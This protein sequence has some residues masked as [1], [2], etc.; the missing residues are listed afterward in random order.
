MRLG[1]DGLNMIRSRVNRGIEANVAPAA[2]FASPHR[3]GNCFESE[4][5][6]L[7]DLAGIS[8]AEAN[9]SA[10]L[11]ARSKET[12]PDAGRQIFTAYLHVIEDDQP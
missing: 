2:F 10:V 1:A 4:D 9:R 8:S 6:T 3:F 11:Q 12:A 5:T 7:M